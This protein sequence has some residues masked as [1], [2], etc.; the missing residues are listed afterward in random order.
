VMVAVVSVIFGTETFD[1]SGPAARANWGNSSVN[2]SSPAMM[3]ACI[4][5][6]RTLNSRSR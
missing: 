2:N 5:F 4:R 6:M 1:I 3:G